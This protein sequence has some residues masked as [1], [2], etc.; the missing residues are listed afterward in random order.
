[1]PEKPPLVASEIENV[2]EPPAVTLPVP[3]LAESEKSGVGGGEL[4]EPP[5]AP[6]AV[7]RP[8]TGRPVVAEDRRAQ[9]RAAGAVPP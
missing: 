7:R 4:V 8:E 2:V 6:S 1:M 9:V 3:G 5:K